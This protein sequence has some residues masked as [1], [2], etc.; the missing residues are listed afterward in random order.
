MGDEDLVRAV[1]AL[2]V[3]VLWPIGLPGRLG[4]VPH[5][6]LAVATVV[7]LCA[8]ALDGVAGWVVVAAGA[9]IAALL[10]RPMTAL[11]HAGRPAGARGHGAAPLV[12]LALAALVS[13]AL[14]AVVVDA[15]RA[16][17]GVGAAL[18]EQDVAVVAAGALTALFI[19]GA[20]LG[21][22]LRPL[23]ERITDTG[24]EPQGFARAG[25]YI[26]WLERGLV[27]T[28]LVAG[29]PEAAALALT[30]KSV[31][32]FPAFSTGSEA[33]A[34][35]VLIGTL[36]S[37]GLATLTAIATRALLGLPAL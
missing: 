1:V 27:F 23:A 11:E 26:G 31:A 3:A 35:Y 18:G 32:R 2:P 10:P 28:F 4:R 30:A 14:A 24:V 12:P 29:Q 20:M 5:A 34:E 21:A 15:G 13:A 17:D 25:L 9:G 37:F 6:V 36:A 19:A 22:L 33:L 8:P 16:V 7:L